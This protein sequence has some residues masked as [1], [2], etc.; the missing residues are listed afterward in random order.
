MTTCEKFANQNN[1]S[2]VNQNNLPKIILNGNPLP[3]VPKVT[4]LGHIL[5]CENSLHLDTHAKKF[6]FI[7]KVNSIFQEF[8]FANP[9]VKVNLYDKYAS[10][11]YGSNL[12]NLFC[13]ETEKV[14][15]AYNVSIRQAFKVP[16]ATHRYLIELLIEHDHI[17]VQLCS[18]F[19]KFV[20]NNDSCSKP[21][22]RILSSVC[23]EDNRTIYCSNIFNIA[24][25]CN[26]EKHLLN[27]SNV[28]TNMKY[29][30]IPLG[31]SWRIDMMFNVIYSKLEHFRIDNFEAEELDDNVEAC[32]HPQ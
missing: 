23:K 15:A 11:F 25:E 4:H 9:E 19:I 10:S 30:E 7:G 16:F 31:E 12:W 32:P 13:S 26:I 20:M 1:L 2:A 3:W 14:Y 6:K 24:K 18:K 17:K 22:I 29:F 27:S 8:Y 21:I 5:D 28:K